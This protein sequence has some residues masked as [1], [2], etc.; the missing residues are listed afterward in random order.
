[1]LSQLEMSD[2]FEIQD[3][4]YHYSD[5]IDQ[6]RFDQ[7]REE[8]FTEDAHIDYSVFGGSV[9]DVDETIGFLKSAVTDELFPNSQHLNANIQIEI[10]GDTAKGRVMCFNPMEMTISD[11]DTQTYIIGLWYVDEYRRTDL[12]W[13][14]SR[15]VEERSWVFNTPDFMNL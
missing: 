13:R 7:L 10:E 3:L 15:R 4:I 11:S 6:K 5:L 1:M 14:M 9:G 2:R 12:G 8:V